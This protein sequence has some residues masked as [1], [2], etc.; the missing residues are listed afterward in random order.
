MASGAR[1]A[2]AKFIQ[3]LGARHRDRQPW[4]VDILSAEVNCLDKATKKNLATTYDLTCG[5]GTEHTVSTRSPHV[6]RDAARKTC[7]ER[8][9]VQSGPKAQPWSRESE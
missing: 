8:N 1:I 5:D 2:G 4:L 6:A 9:G 7:Q 3:Y